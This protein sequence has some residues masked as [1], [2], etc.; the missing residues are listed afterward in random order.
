MYS[1]GSSRASEAADIVIYLDHNASTPV[2]PE[3]AEAMHLALRD[4]GANPSSS[5][6]EG[7]RVR[8][9]LERARAQVATLAGCRADEVVFVSGGTEGDHLAVIGAALARREHG[10]HVAFAAVE[11]HA[12]HGAA[13]VLDELGWTHEQLPCDAQGRTRVDSIETLPAG[14]TVVSVMF[15]NNETGVVQPVRALAERAHARGML[16]HCDAVQGMGKL[17]IDFATL[18]ADFLV[19]SG[20]K[21]G[22]PKG[23]GALIVR[24]G[25]PMQPLFRGSAHEHGRRGGTE[26]VSGIIGLGLACELVGHDLADQAQAMQLLRLQFE[27]ALLAAVPDAMIHGRDAERL[28]NTVNVSFVGARSDHMLM[29]LDARGVCCSAGA[30]CASGGVEPSPVLRAMGVPREW[31]ISALRFSFGRGTTLPE[32]HEAVA[33]VAD[34][35]RRVRAAGVPA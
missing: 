33:H 12:V 9:A 13:E 19:L 11:H 31:A 27:Q 3:V 6:R 30:A 25:T 23:A 5:H 35:V 16:L 34:S 21:F 26:N 1:R 15:A 32:L 8:A 17:P 20:H 24:N 10:R 2:R 22:G 7:Q 29:A 14:T 18:G 28:P 4:L